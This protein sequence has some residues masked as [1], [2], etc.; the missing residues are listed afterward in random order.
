MQSV[1]RLHTG[2]AL[3]AALE[4][5][6]HE[7]YTRS[8]IVQFGIGSLAAAEFGTLPPEGPHVRHRVQGPVELVYLSGL[9]VGQ[10]SGGPYSSHLHLAVADLEG[11][12]R[13]GHLFEATV[14]AAA[15]VGWV[16]LH[17]ARL[18][19]VRDAG[20]EVDFLEF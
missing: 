16:P 10:S 3:V 4:Q 9:I 20:R 18:K 12:V 6:L 1:L 19:R 2:D 7:S 14:G 17:D 8:A 15:E 11:V 13:G 5:S